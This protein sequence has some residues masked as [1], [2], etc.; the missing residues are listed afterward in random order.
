M[1]YSLIKKV[2]ALNNPQRVDKP[3]NTINQ[4]L[5]NNKKAMW[6]YYFRTTTESYKGHKIVYKGL[7]S[8]SLCPKQFDDLSKNWANTRQ[9]WNF[10]CLF[11]NLILKIVRV[12]SLKIL[13]ICHTAYR[14]FALFGI[15]SK[16]TFFGKPYSF[17]PSH[18]QRYG[19]ISMINLLIYFEFASYNI[20][21]F[22]RLN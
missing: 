15:P 3:Y 13:Y 9:T 1:Q 6:I 8:S 19:R 16:T 21:P 4:F 22:S 14:L 17:S 10:V 12:I 7:V 2:W 5:S 18:R 11:H 20:L